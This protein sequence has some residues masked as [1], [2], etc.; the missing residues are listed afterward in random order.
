MRCCQYIVYIVLVV[1]V[2]T[3]GHVNFD[4]CFGLCVGVDIYF[5]RYQLLHCILNHIGHGICRIHVALNRIG[6]G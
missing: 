1:Y 3:V 6:L 4:A 2:I 5:L